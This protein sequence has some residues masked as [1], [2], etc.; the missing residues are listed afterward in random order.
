MSLKYNSKYPLARLEK[1]DRAIIK[2][3]NIYNSIED[4]PARERKYLDV[5]SNRF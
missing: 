1:G 4:I 3:N 2:V 5:K